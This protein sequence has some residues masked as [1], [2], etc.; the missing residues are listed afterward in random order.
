MGVESGPVWFRAGRVRHLLESDLLLL[1]FVPVRPRT[2]QD[3]QFAV[4]KRQS[5]MVEEISAGAGMDSLRNKVSSSQST[6][7][8]QSLFYYSLISSQCIIL[9]QWS[10]QCVVPSNRCFW[11]QPQSFLGFLHRRRESNFSPI[12]P[13]ISVTEAERSLSTRERL[14]IPNIFP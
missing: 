3:V 9:T 11:W 6:S 7:L 2:E 12:S 10:L 13:E 4:R 1:Q 5:V 8:S 14:S